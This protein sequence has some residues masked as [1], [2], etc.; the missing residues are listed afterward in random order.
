[1]EKKQ[2]EIDFAVIC[3][4]LREILGF[5]QQKMADFLGVTLRT[6]QRY[7]AGKG[8]PTAEAAFRLAE[9]DICFRRSIFNQFIIN[10]IKYIRKTA[11]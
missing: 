5:T 3:V 11:K 10:N 4:E 8:K 1:M 9:L 2:D 7:E 6:Y